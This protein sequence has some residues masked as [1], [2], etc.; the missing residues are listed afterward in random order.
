MLVE[1]EA[2]VTGHLRLQQ[3]EVD[4]HTGDTTSL[5]SDEY[6]L[7]CNTGTAKLVMIGVLNLNGMPLAHQHQMVCG[8]VQLCLYIKQHKWIAALTNFC[9]LLSCC[10]KILPQMVEV[11]CSC[12]L[13]CSPSE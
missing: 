6:A 9:S 7:Q 13:T 12:C 4:A 10:C 3:A 11:H 5:S 1:E 2:E 8:Q